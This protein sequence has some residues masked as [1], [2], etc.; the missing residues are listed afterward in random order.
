MISAT[1]DN[2]VKKVRPGAEAVPLPEPGDSS[3]VGPPS[4]NAWRAGT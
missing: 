2:T 1:T 3:P 4:E